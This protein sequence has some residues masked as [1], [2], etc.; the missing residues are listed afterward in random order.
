MKVKLSRQVLRT[1]H[2]ITEKNT[3]ART[4]QNETINHNG[5]K[6]EIQ[7]TV[8]ITQEWNQ[9]QKASSDW[10]RKTDVPR[11]VALHRHWTQHKEQND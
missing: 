8:M 6:D 3:K 1:P 5:G 9:V 2:F 11:G 10:S 7:K 4:L